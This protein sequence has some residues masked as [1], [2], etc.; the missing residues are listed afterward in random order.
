LPFSCSL[1]PTGRFSIAI[2]LKLWT[3]I[4]EAKGSV[5][6]FCNFVFSCGQMLRYSYYL[7]R[8]TRFTSP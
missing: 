2:V 5:F 7:C 4:S 3:V 8:T 1:M 6:L